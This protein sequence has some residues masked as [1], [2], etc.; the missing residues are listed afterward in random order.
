MTAFK[1]RGETMFPAPAAVIFPM[2][3]SLLPQA[4]DHGGSAAVWCGGWHESSAELR[5]GLHV[6]EH[7][8]SDDAEADLLMAVVCFM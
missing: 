7:A 8:P 4:G 1:E 2:V 3:A 6:I 5:D